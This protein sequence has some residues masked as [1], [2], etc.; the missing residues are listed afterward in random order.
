MELTTKKISPTK[1][2]CLRLR[3]ARESRDVSLSYMAKKLRLSQAHVEALECCRFEELPFCTMY[4]K[5]MIRSYLK[6]LDL[7]AKA[8]VDQFVFEEIKPKQKEAA[9]TEKQKK[10]VWYHSLSDLPLLLRLAAVLLVIGGFMGYLG[11]QVK[12]IID[13]P[14]L[15]VYSPAE[16]LVTEDPVLRVQGKTEREVQVHINGKRIMNSENGFFD[17]EVVLSEG[18]NTLQL[19]A[20]KKHGK[21]TR[22]TRHIIYRKVTDISYNQ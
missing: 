6:V 16:G 21:E 5:N 11:M 20:K 1:R 13:P 3:E 8:F 15:M 14:E 4:Q 12:Q 18:V 17:E 7:P 9:D 19:S 22:Q 10:K 2:V